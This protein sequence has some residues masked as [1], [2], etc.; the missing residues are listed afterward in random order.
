MSQFGP[1]LASALHAG[2][3]TY[4]YSQTGCKLL[5]YTEY[6]EQNC[7]CRAEPGAEVF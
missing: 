4:S 6:G 3:G 5:F 7:R 2:H 1:M